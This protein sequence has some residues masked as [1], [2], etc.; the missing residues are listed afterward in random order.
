MDIG[1]EQIGT[2]V[3]YLSDLALS[4]GYYDLSEALRKVAMKH[5]RARDHVYRYPETDERSDK[6]CPID[7][8]T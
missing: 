2:R 5:T 4:R 1:R 7:S 8:E 6:E 3:L